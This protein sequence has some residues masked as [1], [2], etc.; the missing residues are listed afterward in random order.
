MVDSFTDQEL[1]SILAGDTISPAAPIHAGPDLENQKELDSVMDGT[2]QPKGKYQNP[3]TAPFELLRDSYNVGEVPVVRGARGLELMMDMGLSDEEESLRRSQLA[4]PHLEKLGQDV[5]LFKRELGPLNFWTFMSDAANLLPSLVETGQG[6]LAGAASGG[7]VGAGIGFAAGNI[8]GIGAILPEE[9]VTVPTGAALG[10]SRG[11]LTGGIVSG[12]R[13]NMGNVYLDLRDQGISRQNATMFAMSAGTVMGALEYF[14]LRAMSGVARKAFAQ[15][16]RSPAGQAIMSG[17]MQQFQRSGVFGRIAEGTASETLT[18]TGQE[19]TQLTTE[20][21]AQWAET[22]DELWQDPKFWENAQQRLANTAVTTARGSLVLAGAGEVTGTATGKATNSFRGA[23]RKAQAKDVSIGTMLMERGLGAIGSGRVS[24]QQAFNAIKTAF[25]EEGV[26][27]RN[28]VVEQLSNMTDQEALALLDSPVTIGDTLN[29]AIQQNPELAA[30]IDQVVNSDAGQ[31]VMK[32]GIE[33]TETQPPAK[34]GNAA[35]DETALG[36]LFG[37]AP[38]PPVDVELEGAFGEAEADFSQIDDAQVIDPVADEQAAATGG[39][40]RPETRAR[41][42]RINE[43][44]RDLTRREKKLDATVEEKLQKGHKVE[45]VL[46]RIDK[47]LDK[48]EELEIERELLTAGD[49]S[50]DDVAAKRG[51]ARISVLSGLVD[52]IQKSAD[53]VARTRQQYQSKLANQKT[54]YQ[55]RIGELKTKAQ[56]KAAKAR[57]EGFTSGQRAEQKAIRS[58]QN[59]LIQV[60]NAAT[61]DR[62]FRRRLR[63]MVNKVTNRKQFNTAAKNIQAELKKL[64]AQKEAAEYTAAREKV[65]GQ[66]ERMLRDRT[67]SKGRGNPVVGSLDADTV[68]KLKLMRGYL[69]NQEKATNAVTDFLEEFGQELQQRQLHTIPVDR[70]VNFQIAQMALDFEKQDLMTLNTIAG[71]VAQW[72]QDGR[73]AIAAKRERI[74]EQREQERADS[75]AS[76]GVDVGAARKPKSIRNKK[77]RVLKQFK[78]ST[79]TWNTLMDW[80]SPKDLNHRVTEMTDTTV[81]RDE[82]LAGKE[83]STLAFKKKLQDALTA[84]GY[85]KDL[86]SKIYEDSSKQVAFDYVDATGQLVSLEIDRAQLIEAALKMRDT[87]LHESMKNPEKGNGWTFR[88]EAP[89]GQSFEEQVDALLSDADRAIVDGLIDFYQDY[90]ARFNAPYREKYGVDLPMRENYSPVSR[91][92]YMVDPGNSLE[93][94]SLLPGASISRKNTL[95]RVELQNPYESLE[96]H[97][98]QVERFIAYDELVGTIR[99]VFGNSDMRETIKDRYGAGTVEVIDDY[100]ERFVQNRTTNWNQSDSI[101]SAMMSDLSL[102]ALT[103]KSVHQFLTQMTAATAMMANYSPVEVAKGTVAYLQNIK[104]TEAELGKS[105]TLKHRLKS[106]AS[107]EFSMATRK[108]SVGLNLVSALLDK[109]PPT[110]PPKAYNVVANFMYGAMRFGDAAVARVAGAPVYHAEIARGT[111]PEAALMKINQLMEQTQQGDDPSQMP[112]LYANNQYAYLF[113]GMFALQPLQLLGLAQTKIN[114]F[115]NNPTPKQAVQMAGQLAALWFIPGFTYG[116]VRNLPLWLNPPEDDDDL[117]EELWMDMLTSTMLGPANAMPLIGDVIERAWWSAAEF[118]LGV[119]APP[120]VKNARGNP[121]AELYDDAERAIKAWAKLHADDD[122]PIELDID[123]EEQAAEQEKAIRKSIRAISRWGGVS[124]AILNMPGSV[125]SAMEQGDYTAAVLALGGS[126]P[127]K[128]R[129]RLEAAKAGNADVIIF[130][131]D[132]EDGFSFVENIEAIQERLGLNDQTENNVDDEV[133]IFS[134]SQVDAIIDEE[135]AA[136]SE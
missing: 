45:N 44:L 73:E 117:Q 24:I 64:I 111:S 105:P 54:A 120:W 97:I 49:L 32:A 1:D 95:L 103:L 10:A 50:R 55:Q 127:A 72:L 66:I 114:D 65:I 67:R 94:G 25:S 84:V 119:D 52:R 71:N 14:G 20:V 2:F 134:D 35:L 43:D 58:L 30:Q 42:N 48:K 3:W 101:I 34:E 36:A 37:D 9:M 21:L 7:A 96:N 100:V 87:S 33:F 133:D 106:G 115:I 61:T 128:I 6:S 116:L 29:E 26:E 85:K 135:L 28:E 74:R 107:Y 102:S 92:G 112:S 76:V 109:D 124:N 78:G 16:L 81:A 12:A 90:H 57:Q 13:M 17:F 108:N 122:A 8:T 93:F 27:Q 4:K 82:Y 70:L 110:L 98:A 80:I 91:K 15:Q 38:P 18:E 132:D 46:A 136:L 123:E 113:G 22:G 129:Q 86:A 121:V 125:Q 47:I 11:A 51:S 5:E 62:A 69:E 60:I 68:Q 23:I 56:R 39:L 40:T 104:A 89:L 75:F 83:L 63:A 88:G 130:E 131:E 31:Q 59:Q 41:L 77:R 79:L 118:M 53:R 99:N 19:L 126:S